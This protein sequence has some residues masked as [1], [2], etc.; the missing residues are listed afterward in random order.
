MSPSPVDDAE[1]S[2]GVDPEARKKALN[3]APPP[4]PR[5]H[6]VKLWQRVILATGLDLTL[7]GLLV[8]GLV[9][10]GSGGAVVPVLAGHGIAFLI[11]LSWVLGTL[12]SANRPPSQVLGST[13][14]LTPIRYIAGIAALLF[15]TAQLNDS[16]KNVPLIF[17]F[18]VTLVAW[19]MIEAMVTISLNQARPAPEQ[20]WR[21]L[22]AEEQAAAERLKAALQ[23]A[24]ETV[25]PAPQGERGGE[26]DGRAPPGRPA[27]PISS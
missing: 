23:D 18:I 14:L 22:E 12:W 5:G 2:P 10:T 20:G 9:L 26:V 17:S 27:G 3:K 25:G 6:L 16:A 15:V 19:H 11:G 24:E 21:D 1:P 7:V 8:T 13:V 4:V